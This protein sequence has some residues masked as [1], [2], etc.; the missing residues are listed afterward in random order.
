M[1]RGIAPDCD[2]RHG[3]SIDPTNI[4]TLTAL[5]DAS[6]PAKSSAHL[7]QQHGVLDGAQV[8]VLGGHHVVELRA[9][10]GKWRPAA[11]AAREESRR[12]AGDARRRVDN[13]VQLR[14]QRRQHLRSRRQAG[15]R[16]ELSRQQWNIPAIFRFPDKRWAVPA[17]RGSSLGYE[18]WLITRLQIDSLPTCTILLILRITVQHNI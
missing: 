18:L 3:S 2:E 15:A 13:A 8:R 17:D 1:C 9:A 6:V 11:A 5:V 4:C 12:G 14:V 10:G 7:D 16:D